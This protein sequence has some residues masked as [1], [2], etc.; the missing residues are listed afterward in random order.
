[1][2]FFIGALALAVICILFGLPVAVVLGWVP[3]TATERKMASSSDRD[4]AP[5]SVP[6]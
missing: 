4:N 6:N 5:S 2:R 3:I 1:M